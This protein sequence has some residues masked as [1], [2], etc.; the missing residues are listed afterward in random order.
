M[1][2]HDVA[3]A[4]GLFEGEGCFSLARP[5]GR[6]SR[7]IS[8]RLVTTDQDVM[9][10]F[11]AVVGVGKVYG[12]KFRNTKDKPYWEFTTTTFEH[13]QYLIAM[14]WAWLGIRRRERAAELLT[15]YIGDL[16]DAR[17]PFRTPRLSTTDLTELRRRV[18]SGESQGHIAASLG[19]SQAAVSRIASGS[20]RAVL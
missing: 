11:H 6:G 16:R 15:T 7:R 17:K 8:A 1:R 13:A 20:R 3:W 14:F 12:P 9:L 10:R 18:A 4:A 5:K 2:S 19:V